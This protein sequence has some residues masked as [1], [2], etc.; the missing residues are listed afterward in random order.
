LTFLPIT[1]D[2]NETVIKET[3]SV[4]APVGICDDCAEGDV[5]INQAVFDE[6]DG[7]P[8]V[9]VINNVFPRFG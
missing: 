1:T 5:V 8:A 7:D 9:G 3:T 4:L 2:E 6:L